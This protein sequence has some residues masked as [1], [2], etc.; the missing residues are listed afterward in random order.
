MNITKELDQIIVKY[1]LDRYYPRYRLKLRAEELIEKLILHTAETARIVLVGA[2]GDDTNYT[3][4]LVNRYREVKC[5]VLTDPDIAQAALH[6]LQSADLVYLVSFRN[7]WKTKAVLDEYHIRYEDLYDLFLCEG[8]VFEDEYYLVSV[9]IYQDHKLQVKFGKELR[10]RGALQIEYYFLTKQYEQTENAALREIISKKKLFLALYMKNFVEAE[11]CVKTMRQ[12]GT[13]IHIEEAWKEITGLLDSIKTKM[14]QRR[15]EDILWYWLDSVSYDDAEN[16]L[17]LQE[18]KDRS[19]SFTNA[20]TNM[21]YTHATLKAAFCQKRSVADRSYRI[22]VISE[23]NSNLYFWLKAN[24]YQIKVLSKGF[25]KIFNKECEAQYYLAASSCL[26]KALEYLTGD[27]RKYFMLIQALEESHSPYFSFQMPTLANPAEMLYFGKKELDEQLAFYGSLLGGGILQIFMSDHGWQG[28]DF[29]ASHHIHMDFFHP[30]IRP[31][32]IDRIFSILDFYPVLRQLIEDRHI[33]DDMP[34]REYAPIE[35]LD[36]YSTADIK[37]IFRRKNVDLIH[38]FGYVGVISQDEIYVRF[39][40]GNEYQ[41]SRKNPHWRPKLF[42]ESDIEKP[43]NAAK[44]RDAAGI[45]PLELLREDKFAYTRYLH[46]LFEIYRIREKELINAFNEKIAALLSECGDSSVA[47]RTGGEHSYYLYAILEETIKRKIG[48]FIDYTENCLCASYGK[49]VVDSIEN[50]GKEIKVVLL[51]SFL[52]RQQL[53]DEAVTY[54]ADIMVI[55]AYTV[56]EQMGYCFKQE[57]YGTM[58]L[59]ESDFDHVYKNEDDV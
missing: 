46:K 16:M 47:I 45:Y 53:R 26:W 59:R 37:E 31:Q 39:S 17:Y 28:G 11:K 23:K 33:H 50:V 44:L 51:S 12:D 21:P 19:V 14:S 43:E 38:A 9:D 27:D 8:L 49:K 6:D 20:F 18:M 52:Y 42:V 56:F 7:A 58:G 55:D 34:A 13:D 29:L 5:Y 3:E 30:D 35:N 48:L 1:Q 25:K 2:H 4:E 24:G 41:H 15:A 22:E 40:V 36:R 54:P 10:D 57:F 32:K